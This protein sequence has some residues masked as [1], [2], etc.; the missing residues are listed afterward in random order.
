[1]NLLIVS[2]NFK[3]GGLET[4]INTYYDLI[5]KN[6]NN[7]IFAFSNYE[8]NGYLK[9]A[10]IYTGFNFNF[11]VSI[12]GFIQDV[13]RLIKIIKD[14]DI[15]TIQVH[16]Y[17]SLFPAIFASKITNTK[18]IYT[19]HG[20][21]SINFVRALNDSLIFSFAI[22]YGIDK[23]FCVTENVIKNIQDFHNE[24]ISFIPNIIDEDLYFEHKVSL[25]KKWALVSRLDSDKYSSIIKFLLMLPELN[26][27][28]IDIYG[29]GN[30]L[31]DLKKFITKNHLNK[32]VN[33]MGFRKNMYESL[34]DYT[35][36]IG[37]GRVVLESLCMNYPTI[38][39][40][41]NKVV[42]VIDKEIYDN[43]RNINFV[44]FMLNDISIEKFNNQLDKINN[45]K[46]KEFQFRNKVIKDFGKNQINHYIEE[47]NNIHPQFLD[48]FRQTYDQIRKIYNQKEY[49]YT[50]YEVFLS[51]Y[52]NLVG[53][54][55][56]LYYKELSISYSYIYNL[57]SKQ[58]LLDQKL[59]NLENKINE[60]DK[61]F[62]KLQEENF[63]YKNGKLYKLSKKIYSFKS[64][65][66]KNK[67]KRGKTHEKN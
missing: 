49:F 16:P 30:K 44:P 63:E 1:M 36:V 8:D 65:L 3:K 61:I 10:K 39:I 31:E 38:L 17:Y 21:G 58:N 40:G 12:E 32:K 20:Y 11:N 33:I 6:Y 22:E 24:N 51:I 25:N 5:N 67:S 42:G 57:I 7:V 4:H 15:D 56:N 54:S 27:N 64:K 66:K 53:F 34:D 47:I 59:A 35:G 29:S 45:N 26:I 46:F 2:E 55:R 23:F 52:D 19:Y 60:N 43:S 18:L 37:I 62:K 28:K 50:S 9:N 14:N 13:E 48:V 41:Y